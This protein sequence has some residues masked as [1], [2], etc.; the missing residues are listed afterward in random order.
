MSGS[1]FYYREWSKMAQKF[2]ESFYNSK[3]WRK[4]REGFLKKKF[5]TCEHCGRYA[6]IVHHKKP[7]T[8]GNI[9]NPYISL[10]WDNLKALCLMCHQDIHDVN[11]PTADGIKFDNTGM[12]Y[13][14]SPPGA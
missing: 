4:C 8:P 13:E 2:S 14:L 5:H 7:L 10:N 6:F 3:E 9:N 12:V 11:K 1:I